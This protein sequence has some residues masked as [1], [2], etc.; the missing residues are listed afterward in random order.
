MDHA[1]TRVALEKHH[2]R[3]AGRLLRLRRATI[4]LIAW[5]GRRSAAS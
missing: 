5:M 2:P 4:P 3:V 1:R